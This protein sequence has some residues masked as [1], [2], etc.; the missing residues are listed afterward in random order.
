MDTAVLRITVKD[1]DDNSPKFEPE[2]YTAQLLEHSS[3]GSYITAVKATDKD[4][5]QYLI[6]NLLC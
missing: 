1:I 5:V 4:L 6:D 3:Q 2:N